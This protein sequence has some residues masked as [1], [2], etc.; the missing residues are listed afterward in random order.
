M[1]THPGGT[2]TGEEDGGIG[3]GRGGAGRGNVL[4]SPGRGRVHGEHTAKLNQTHL[5]FLGSQ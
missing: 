5:G 1:S 4:P 3:H 2:L